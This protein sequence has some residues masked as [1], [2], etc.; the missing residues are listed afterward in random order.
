MSREADRIARQ[1]RKVAELDARI[2]RL[3]TQR[4]DAGE[5]LADMLSQY[6][7]LYGEPYAAGHRVGS[8]CDHANRGP[9]ERLPPDCFVCLDCGA[10]GRTRR[11][12]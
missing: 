2:G 10:V 6:R 8:P 11:S 3:M 1:E 12:A 7:R 4:A 5:V 9:A